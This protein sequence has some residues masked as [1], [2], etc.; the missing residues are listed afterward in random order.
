MPYKNQQFSWKMF[1]HIYYAPG[2][3]SNNALV[4]YLLEQGVDC[5][6]YTKCRGLCGIQRMA[7]TTGL[8]YGYDHIGYVGRYCYQTKAEAVDALVNWDGK[9]DPGGDWIKHKGKCE[10]A[11]RDYT[12]K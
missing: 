12:L 2:Y 8:F 9:Q 7:F 1:V 5:L 4:K 3:Y 11:N 6:C 10:Y